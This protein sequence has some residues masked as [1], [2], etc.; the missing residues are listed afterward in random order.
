MAAAGNFDDEPG[1]GI[2]IQIDVEDG[3]GIVRQA[4]EMSEA[5]SRA[6]ATD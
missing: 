6:G 4:A 2:A 5:L 3:V 1:T